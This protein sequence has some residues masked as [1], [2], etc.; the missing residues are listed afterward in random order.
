[1]KRKLFLYRCYLLLWL[2]YWWTKY[3]RAYGPDLFYTT[4]QEKRKRN[5][6]IK[7]AIHYNRYIVKPGGRY[8]SIVLA[9][10]RC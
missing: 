2:G 8:R 1:M 6:M 5:R 3:K 9:G 4:P 7:Q 10:R